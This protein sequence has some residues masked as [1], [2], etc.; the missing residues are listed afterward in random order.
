MLTDLLNNKIISREELLRLTPLPLLGIIV[1]G[2]TQKNTTEA[3]TLKTA[4]SESLRSIRSNLSYIS[5]SNGRSKVI[6]LTSSISGEGKSFCAY[7]LGHIL[8]I[9]NKKTLLINAD[10]RKPGNYGNELGS[11][12]GPGLSNYLS[13]MSTLNSVIQKSQ[14]E[15]LYVINSGDLPPNPSELLLSARMKH[16]LD[17]LKYEFDYIVLDTPPIGLISDALELMKQADINIV[18]TRQ[19]YTKK[20]F[21]SYINELYLNQKYPNMVVV[22][23]DVSLNKSTF[24]YGAV[25]YGHGY[26]TNNK[27]KKAWFG[28]LL[29]K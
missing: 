1:H 13:G 9:S 14:F 2:N 22:F 5:E 19:G 7:N 20:S 23:N 12:S 25:G 24:T 21:L 6:V 16:M 10:M 17:E 26:Y 27:D 18:V 8:S 11:E 3:N 29:H 4:L 28:K 15:D